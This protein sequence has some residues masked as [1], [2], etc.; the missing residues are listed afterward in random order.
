M[1]W[2]SWP[3]EYP[4]PEE[5]TWMV[6]AVAAAALCLLFLVL[7]L[8]SS[9]RARVAAQ[10]EVIL[11]QDRRMMEALKAPSSPRAVDAQRDAKS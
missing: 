3:Q 4:W 8:R 10:H 6:L 5:Y 7:K 9:R 2:L 1:D 11:A